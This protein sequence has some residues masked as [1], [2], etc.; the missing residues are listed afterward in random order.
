[1]LLGPAHTDAE[2]ERV[3]C[4]GEFLLRVVFMFAG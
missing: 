4:L 1:M 3:Q 2:G